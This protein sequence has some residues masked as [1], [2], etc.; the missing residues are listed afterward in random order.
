MEH[1]IRH[2]AEILRHFD[3]F[4][5]FNQN[6]KCLTNLKVYDILI[7]DKGIEVNLMANAG[8]KAK[9]ETPIYNV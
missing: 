8:R 6:V 1:S 3:V 5:F 2:S 4:V 7:I 9:D